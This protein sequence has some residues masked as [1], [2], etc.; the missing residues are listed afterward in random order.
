MITHLKLPMINYK[1]FRYFT[2]LAFIFLY[3]GGCAAFKP[4]YVDSRVTPV[5]SKDKIEKNIREGKG[6][7][8]GNKLLGSGN[9]TFNFASSNPMWRA[10]IEL[11]DFT[12]F[13][14]I[15][16][17]GGIIITDWYNDG[18][19]Q[20]EYIKITVRFLSPEIRA[21]GIKII[22]HKKICTNNSNC[23]ISKIKS[24]ISQEIKLAILKKATLIQKNDL[25]KN[26]DFELPDD[27]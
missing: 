24:K 9:N 11:L 4:K 16:Y 14:N 10:S 23:K 27:F 19:S 25:P 5:N 1:K 22:V 2:F 15:D 26:P 18:N 21:D 12:P 20:N 3:V 13:D 8:I 6:F 17:A 7:N